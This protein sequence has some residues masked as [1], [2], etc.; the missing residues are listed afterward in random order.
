MRDHIWRAAR[1]PSTICAVLSGALLGRDPPAALLRDA[2]GRALDGQ[3]GLVLVS[4]EAGIGKTALVSAL[5]EEARRR[6]AHVLSGVCWD[7][8]GAPGYWPWVQVVRSLEGAAPEKWSQM[9]AVADAGLA[10]LVGEVSV[11]LPSTSAADS[12]FQ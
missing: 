5:A 7:G 1:R 2:L 3:G 10:P 12:L 11:E 8:E 6:G 4:G 9:D